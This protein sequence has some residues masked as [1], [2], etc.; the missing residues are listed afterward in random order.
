[1]GEGMRPPSFHNPTLSANKHVVQICRFSPSARCRRW[2][3]R[4]VRWASNLASQRRRT[5]L[6]RH[7][8]IAQSCH[9]PTVS[10]RLRTTFPTAL[11]LYI[12]PR[13]GRLRKD[14]RYRSC[15]QR[16]NCCIWKGKIHQLGLFFLP[17]ACY[18]VIHGRLTSGRKASTLLHH[19]PA[20]QAPSSLSLHA[21]VN[22]S[23]TVRFLA[24]TS[25]LEHLT[26]RRSTVQVRLGFRTRRLDARSRQSK[27]MIM[28]SKWYRLTSQTSLSL[29]LL[30]TKVTHAQYT[31]RFRTWYNISAC[32]QQH[33]CSSFTSHDVV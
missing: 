1:M 33:Q 7:W 12:A 26:T 13:Q 18:W 24:P 3:Y 5:K 17:E 14:I 10:G 21:C 16:Q 8:K 4:R 15:F 28:I 11:S 27:C 29:F 2:P 9:S 23:S 25:A 20:A 19:G 22:Q 31:R 6:K 32:I 30:L